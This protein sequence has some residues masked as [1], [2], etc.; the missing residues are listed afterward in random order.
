MTARPRPFWGHPQEPVLF[1]PATEAPASPSGSSSGATATSRYPNKPG[2]PSSHAWGA[3]SFL[4]GDW[5]QPGPE[6]PQLGS[7]HA[8]GARALHGSAL[9]VAVPMGGQ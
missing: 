9:G 5:G 6:F 8:E 4:R 3:S 2:P 1:S 7:L